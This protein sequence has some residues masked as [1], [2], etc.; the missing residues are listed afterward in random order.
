M[1]I[2]IANVSAPE[3]I[4]LFSEHDDFMIDFLGEDS[5]YYTRYSAKEKIKNVW[6]ACCDDTS[7]GCVAYRK[8]IAGCGRS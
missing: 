3:V 7:V 2:V 1:E 6:M 8:K 5:I 4:A